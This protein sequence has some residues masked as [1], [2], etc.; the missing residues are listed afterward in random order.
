M[1]PSAV[2]EIFRGFSYFAIYFMSHEASEITAKYEKQ[3]IYLSILHEPTY[4]NYFIVT[5]LLKS[6]KAGVILL[7][8]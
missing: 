2:W 4:E 3:R 8:Y 5:C 1:V 7:T 6:N